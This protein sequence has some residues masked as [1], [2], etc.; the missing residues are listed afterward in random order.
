MMDDFFEGCLV[1]AFYTGVAFIL[2]ILPL[3]L[4]MAFG[5]ILIKA[6]GL[7]IGW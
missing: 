3:A 6:F 1:E 4:G 2:S 5:F 7:W